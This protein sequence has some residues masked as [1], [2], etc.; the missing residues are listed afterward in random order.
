[1][2]CAGAVLTSATLSPALSLKGEGAVRCC[3]Q[4][5]S[6]PV[7]AF[8][9]PIFQDD[10]KPQIRSGQPPLPLGR[11]LGRGAES[12]QHTATTGEHLSRASSLLQLQ[13]YTNVG[14]VERSD[15]HRHDRMG[16]AKAQ[17]I[18]RKA[19]HKRRFPPLGNGV[20]ICP[21]Y[22]ASRT[23]QSVVFGPLSVVAC[24]MEPRGRAL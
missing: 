4:A 2:V 23:F 1:M 13:E 24:P 12:T 20:F 5:R 11:G 8:V 10:T 15:T 16:F 18:L 22:P 21:P 14:W 17:P 19:A 7:T 6:H 9:A 3:L